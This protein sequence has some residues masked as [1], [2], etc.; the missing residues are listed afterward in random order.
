MHP[1]AQMGY[2]MK[3]DDLIKRSNVLYDEAYAKGDDRITRV[4]GGE[5][6]RQYYRFSEIVNFL[7]GITSEPF[8]ILDIGCGNGEL[9]HYLNYRG[10]SG[11]YTGVD[12][13]ESLLVEAK[14]QFPSSQFQNVSLLNSNI[15]S[16]ET[17]MLHDYVVLSGVFNIDISQDDNFH[18]S[19]I[20]RMFSLSRRK[21]VFNAASS[22]VN[23]QHPAMYHIDPSKLID[24]V[25]REV[26]KKFELRHHFLPYNYTVCLHHENDWM[27]IQQQRDARR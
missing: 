3:I 25:A 9:L 13:N 24:W 16:D 27:S 6:Y 20:K 7:D 2:K 14:E 19:I 12:I 22:H 23:Y 21:V 1:R 8:S 4:K 5:L 11:Q 17:I 10:F 26:T 18:K 15:L